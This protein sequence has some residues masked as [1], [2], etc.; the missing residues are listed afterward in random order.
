[1]AGR[2]NNLIPRKKGDPPFPGAGR[3]KGSLNAKTILEKILASKSEGPDPFAA[4][5]EKAK[6]VKLSQKQ[7]IMYQLV[8]K[9]RQGD[10]AAIKEI[11][12]RTEGK[13][14]QAVQH[15]YPEGTEINVKVGK[16]IRPGEAPASPAVESAPDA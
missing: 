4:D 16:P 13:A 14:L 1:M 10:M 6:K 9:A 12:D 3:P 15:E 5:P 2:N 7:L 11:L 8:A